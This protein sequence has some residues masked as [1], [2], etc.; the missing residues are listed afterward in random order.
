MFNPSSEWMAI[1][2]SLQGFEKR[3]AMQ[4]LGED[5]GAAMIAYGEMLRS[6][7]VAPVFNRDAGIMLPGDDIQMAIYDIY[8]QIRRVRQQHVKMDEPDYRLLEQEAKESRW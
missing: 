1:F 8:L 2:E 6:G 3:M 5:Y 7:Y 4:R